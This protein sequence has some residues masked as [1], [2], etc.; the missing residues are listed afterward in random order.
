VWPVKEARGLL[1]AWL[2]QGIAEG[3]VSAARLLPLQLRCLP[4]KRAETR[5]EMREL[6]DRE[7]ED[8]PEL[9]LILARALVEE[10]AHAALE[11]VA[12][13]LARALLRDGQANPAAR[14][15]LSKVLDRARDGVLAAD[16][17][18]A[19][20]LAPT[21]PLARRSIAVE[22]TVTLAEVGELAIHDVAP[23]GNG[24]V[25]IALGE[26][27]VRIVQRAGRTVASFAAPALQLVLADHGT[28][29]LALISR[30]QQVHVTR[31]ELDSRRAIESWRAPLTAWA[32]SYDGQGWFAAEADRLLQVD[33]LSDRYRALWQ[34]PKMSFV[35]QGIFRSRS[36]LTLLAAEAASFEEAFGARLELWR[37][38]LPSLALRARGTVNEEGQPDPGGGVLFGVLANGDG[39]V[40]TG[41]FD[42]E[43]RA[44]R[45]HFIPPPAKSRT[46]SAALAV[47]WPFRLLAMDSTMVAVEFGHEQGLTIELLDLVQHQLRA[48]VHLEGAVKT[49]ARFTTDALWIGDDRGRLLKVDL[50]LGLLTRLTVPT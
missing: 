11:P 44:A 32:D 48:R 17:P 29:A 30:D 43:S 21:L 39:W 50:A 35:G 9:R 8:G 42:P 5:M 3:P 36:C 10:E 14:E 34:L 40:V 38:E 31:L 49:C 28:R 7:D 47:R 25:L 16:L 2:T 27:G 22:W 18:P 26:A 41:R 24:R 23:L 4:E 13:E 1:E 37:Y 45:L 33:A 20:G 46:S 6:M 15:L 12:R 19:R